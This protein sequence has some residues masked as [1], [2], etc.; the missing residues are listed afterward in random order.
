MANS[1]VFTRGETVVCSL[2]VETNAGTATTPDTSYVV[3]IEDPDGTEVVDA[4]TMTVDGTG[5]LSKDYT[6]AADDVL[7]IYKVEYV[8]V[9]GVRKIIKQDTFVVQALTT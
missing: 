8:L 9:H 1:D 6:L 3:T 5:E 2:Q 7:G 4:A